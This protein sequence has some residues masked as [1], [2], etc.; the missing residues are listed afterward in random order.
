MPDSTIQNIK[1]KI[2]N[3]PLN[4]IAIL[5]LT[6][7]A[8]KVA[9]EVGITTLSSDYGKALGIPLLFFI[10]INLIYCAAT[11]RDST[12]RAYYSA[13][14]I[15]SITVF[16]FALFLEQFAATDD[17]DRI[18]F[19]LVGLSL[20]PFAQLQTTNSTIW[21]REAQFIGFTIVLATQLALILLT[22]ASSYNL[23]L[24]WIL[25]L[26]F[27]LFVKLQ[28]TN[29][30]RPDPENNRVVSPEP[31]SSSL[32]PCAAVTVQEREMIAKLTEDNRIIHQLIGNVAHDLKT[33]SHLVLSLS[34]YNLN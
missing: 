10:A 13:S 14:V 30:N 3:C 25:Y 24:T 6:A 32:T 5:S 34:F 1:W 28:N 27:L 16:A 15:S 4:S 23:W 17:A 26:S 18:L 2:L 22:N 11:L 31:S 20:A 8:L 29:P 12:V 33:V 9:I 19:A 21:G 7:A